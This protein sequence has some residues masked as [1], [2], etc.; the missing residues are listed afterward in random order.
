MPQIEFG[1]KNTQLYNDYIAK[2]DPVIKEFAR[3]DQENRTRMA[4]ALVDNF[5]VYAKEEENL[6]IPSKAARSITQSENIVNHA[7]RA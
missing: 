6:P 2:A 7:H 5:N 4:R 3:C 1:Q